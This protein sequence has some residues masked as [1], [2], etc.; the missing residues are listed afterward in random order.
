MEID[1]QEL[2]KGL[3]DLV[4]QTVKGDAARIKKFS[5]KVFDEQKETIERL[6]KL[7][8]N[9]EISEEELKSELE[10]EKVTI[11]NIYLSLKVAGKASAQKTTNAVVNFLWDSIIRI[12][13]TV[14]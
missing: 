9:G 7:F 11:Q 3:V 10:D 6:T 5:E 13:K 4:K 14:L 8:V 1:F 12:A 2:Q